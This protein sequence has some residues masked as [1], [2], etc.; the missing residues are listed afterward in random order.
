MHVAHFIHRAP[1]AVGGAEAYCGRLA[2]HHAARG[3]T[4]TVWTTTAVALTDLWH[5]GPGLPPESRTGPARRYRPL[6]FPLRRY[7]LKAASLVPVPAW[8]C[9][10]SPANPVC[11]A[12]WRDAGTF[13]GPLDAVHALAFPYS[14]PAACGLR[15]ARRHG[16]PFVLTPFLHLGDPADPR[17]RTR[18]QYTRRP[19][20]WLLRRA[21]AVFVQTASE[22]AAVESLGVPPARVVVQGLGVNP[23][24]CTGGDRPAARAAWRVPAGA[25]VVGHLANLSVEKGSVD[26]V[27][28]AAALPGHVRV[29]LAGPAMPNF[30]Q[31]WA[32]FSGRDRVTRLG[33]VTAAGKRDFFAG[34]DLFALPS[35]S[36]SFGLVLLEAWANGVPVV[37]YRAGGP[38]DLVRD[39]F[40]G[41][42]AAC[43]DTG[44]LAGCLRT[45]AADAGRRH[46]LGAAGRARVAAGEF[47]WAGRL[48]V[49][50]D[51]LAALTGSG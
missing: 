12:M 14:F 47:D 27:R 6:G 39:G 25:V 40:D 7:V 11:P 45:L 49:V 41:L 5:P 38:A 29:V 4:P 16:V 21:D 19:L 24:D 9:L 37:V 30:E 10:T 50:R 34:L 36:D 28:A 17:D 33:P 13:A 20:R 3:D 23:A 31:F 32:T 42:Q 44:A 46:R 2:A 35:R 8:Q 48:D 18:R 1:P 26:L 43:G 15:L 22:R 51:R